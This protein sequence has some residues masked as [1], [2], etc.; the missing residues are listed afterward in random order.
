M[1]SETVYSES[2]LETA[3]IDMLQQFILELGKGFLFGTHQKRL[4]LEEYNYYVDLVL[5][6]R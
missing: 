3:I 1:K 2:K 5:Y 4:T 6:N